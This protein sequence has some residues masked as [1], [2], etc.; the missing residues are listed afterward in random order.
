MLVTVINQLSPHKVVLSKIAVSA[1]TATTTHA[2]LW[3]LCRAG[4]RMPIRLLRDEDQVFTI[5]YAAEQLVETA[6]SL[7]QQQGLDEIFS[8]AS[9]TCWETHGESIIQEAVQVGFDPPEVE[10]ELRSSWSSRCDSRRGAPCSQ[11][12]G[13]RP[14]AAR[15]LQRNDTQEELR[16]IQIRQELHEARKQLHEQ[17]MHD[18]TLHHTEVRERAMV[19]RIT[20]PKAPAV[21]PNVLQ[22]L[23]GILP[24]RAVRQAQL[25]MHPGAV[26]AEHFDA[27]D[28][29]VSLARLAQQARL[30]P[31]SGQNESSTAELKA[32]Q[33]ALQAQVVAR[34]VTLQ[35]EEP[36][37]EEAEA[38]AKKWMD[39][40]QAT[41]TKKLEAR[42][43]ARLLEEVSLTEQMNQLKKQAEARALQQ[44]EARTEQWK[45]LE[46]HAE[47]RSQA[48]ALKEFEARAEARIMVEF[49]AHTEARALQKVSEFHKQIRESEARADAQ[50]A[51]K[52]EA[53]TMKKLNEQAEAGAL[54][55]EEARAEQLRE[56]EVRVAARFEAER[57]KELEARAEARVMDLFRKQMDLIEAR[58]SQRVAEFQ[59]QMRKLKARTEAGVTD[60]AEA[61]AMQMQEF[62]QIKAQATEKDESD[63]PLSGSPAKRP[64]PE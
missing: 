56:V 14:P 36:S 8:L 19:A 15:T 21:P 7:H 57:F 38:Q 4:T 16:R 40:L 25:T 9:H 44:E 59:D 50:A 58:A 60:K 45:E 33:Q 20:V 24:L 3:L 35:A 54:Q 18:A 48:K 11:S 34:A 47:A 26:P 42:A 41:R 12:P 32:E 28:T 10:D 46:V 1:F 61:Q 23:Q 2:L 43:E 30:T 62:A 64:R 39:V 5:Q 52:A 6:M 31:P 37:L 51:E 22:V 17:E 13:A 27:S 49:E 29:L 55:K 53:H 63:P